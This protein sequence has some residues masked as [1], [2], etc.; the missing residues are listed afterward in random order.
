VLKLRRGVVAGTSPLMVEVE[1]EARPAW[2]DTE[3]V[4]EMR[5]GDEVVVN[6]EALDLGLGSGGFDVVHVN[7]TRGMQG[8]G[9][10]GAHVIKLNYTS[11]QHPI[12][13]VEAADEELAASGTSEMPALVIPLHGHLAPA[14]WAAEQAASEI[15]VGF[16]QSAGGA[17]PGSMSRDVGTLR[18]RNLLCD[19]V[20]VA[21]A[22]GGEREAMSVVGALDA[23]ARLGWDAA[24]VGP[25]PGIVG[26]ESRYGHGGM[27][28][29]DNAHAAL[30]LGLP[31]LLAPR[32]SAADPRKRHA[33]LS[34]HTETVLALLL[35]G[36]DI[37]VPAEF[38]EVRTALRPL[39]GGVHETSVHPADLGGYATSGLPAQVMGRGI[40]DDPAFFAAALAAGAGLAAAAQG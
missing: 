10:G 16:V 24:I 20:T 32:F 18:Q 34:H 25:G 26:S 39:L 29:L 2:A 28:A 30:S 4:G 9:G 38:E 31:T 14:A 21:P 7:L 37:P 22:Y 13:P 23:G 8:V 27:E 1:G 40:D 6:T 36:L 19:H 5:E 3:L 11:L 15:K 17:L 35:V 12:E 33:G